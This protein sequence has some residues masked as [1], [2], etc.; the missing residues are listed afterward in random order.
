[1]VTGNL[2]TVAGQGLMRLLESI[3]AGT[4]FVIVTRSYG[5]PAGDEFWS[6]RWTYLR[7]DL[8][9]PFLDWDNDFGDLEGLITHRLERSVIYS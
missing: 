9:D 7:E 8:I 4:T 6:W 1:M 3:R 5:R 2:D